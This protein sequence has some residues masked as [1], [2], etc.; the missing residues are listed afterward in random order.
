MQ[1]TPYERHR[2]MGHKVTH[3]SPNGIDVV[4]ECCECNYRALLKFGDKFPKTLF[5]NLGGLEK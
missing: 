1:M 2:E 4:E 5:K 3:Y